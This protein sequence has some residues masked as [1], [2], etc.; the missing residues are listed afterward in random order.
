MAK[1][2]TD[3][4]PSESIV[5]VVTGEVVRK[6]T[7]LDTPSPSAKPNMLR[8]ITDAIFCDVKVDTAYV[9]PSLGSVV[10][11]ATLVNGKAYIAN[12]TP[13]TAKQNIFMVNRRLAIKYP[14]Q[15]QA[16]NI[17]CI[18]ALDELKFWSDYLYCGS[19]PGWTMT[20]GVAKASTAKKASKSYSGADA[21]RYADA[22]CIS[23]KDLAAAERFYP[24]QTAAAIL[25]YKKI[26]ESVN[27]SE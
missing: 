11:G 16:F 15:V 17:P 25:E 7:P 9:E 12:L 4:I 14:M 24:E 1:K 2:K 18:N 8:E 10:H 23:M 21:R 19:K 22:Y 3:I 26:I 5:D 27:K 6:E 20:K 13:E